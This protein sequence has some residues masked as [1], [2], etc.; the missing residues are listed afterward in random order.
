[1]F[2]LRQEIQIYQAGHFALLQEMQGGGLATQAEKD[3]TRA[4]GF[5]SA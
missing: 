5:A 1:M 3:K 2:V 4:A